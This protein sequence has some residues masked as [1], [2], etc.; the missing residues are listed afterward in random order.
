MFTRNA[1]GKAFNRGLA[2]LTIF[3]LATFAAVAQGAKPAA[4]NFDRTCA[5]PPPT[6]DPPTASPSTPSQSG[7]SSHMAGV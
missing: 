5:A 6:D 1:V 3:V 4:P 2:L 7:P